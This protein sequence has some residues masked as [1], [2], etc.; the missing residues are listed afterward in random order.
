M[1]GRMFGT[2]SLSHHSVKYL[3][4]HTIKP[5]G[6]RGCYSVYHVTLFCVLLKKV[7]QVLKTTRLG[8]EILVS[9]HIASKDV[10]KFSAVH[11][12]HSEVMS[13]RYWRLYGH[14]IRCCAG[15]S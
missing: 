11:L 9:S 12:V 8:T 10:S 2:V 14:G 5:N 6:D 15:N 7:S 4:F 1:S 3:F 13:S